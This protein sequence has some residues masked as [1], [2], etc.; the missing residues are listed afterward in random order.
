MKKKNIVSRFPAEFE[1]YKRSKKEKANKTILSLMRVLVYTIL[2][3]GS[4]GLV[5]FFSI[6]HYETGFNPKVKV[7]MLFCMILA[8]FFSAAYYDS[9]KEEV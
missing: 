5:Y 7:L 4:F 8:S 2:M 6:I 3:V 9:F 1:E